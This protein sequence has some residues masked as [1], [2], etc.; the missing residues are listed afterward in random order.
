MAGVL[1]SAYQTYIAQLYEY[2]MDN[3][4]V[5]TSI[6]G[7]PTTGYITATFADPDYFEQFGVMHS[8]LD[9]ANGLGTPIYC[10]SDN[11]VVDSV[12]FDN[13]GYGIFVKLR[14]E[15]SG[16]YILYAHL[17]TIVPGI[18]PG[19]HVEWGQTIGLM[20]S[21]GNSTGNH[22]HYEIRQPDNTPVNPEGSEDCCD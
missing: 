17:W 14:D 3:V 8:G 1:I 11:A 2:F 12:G 21:T 6:H 20:D 13:N 15:E 9:I 16:W 5:P 19:A 18:Y 7:M 22:L 10:T 4:D